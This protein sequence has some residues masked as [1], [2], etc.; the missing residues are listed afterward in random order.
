MVAKK[1]RKTKSNLLLLM[2]VLLLLRQWNIIR[3]WPLLILRY[4]R[5]NNE[6][7][8]RFKW[9]GQLKYSGNRTII[10]RLLKRL[11]FAILYQILYN[12]KCKI[13]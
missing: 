5:L 6:Q 13:W 7:K 9:G 1:M 10:T 12:F 4:R 11:F 8:K 2:S 3:M